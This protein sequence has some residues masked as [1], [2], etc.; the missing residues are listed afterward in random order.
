M[1]G[2]SKMP[3]IRK[4]EGIAHGAHGKFLAE[5][6]N[7]TTINLRSDFADFHTFFTAHFKTAEKKEELYFQYKIL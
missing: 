5:I 7:Y 3:L 1:E 2:S 4:E 6:G